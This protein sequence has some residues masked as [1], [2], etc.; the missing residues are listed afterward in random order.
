LNHTEEELIGMLNDFLALPNETEWLEFKEAKNQYDF[1]KIGKYFSALS[2]EACL[3]GE[4]SSWLIFGVNKKHEI[5][6]SEYRKNRPSLD[7]LKHELSENTTNHISF[8]E[9]YELILPEGRI[10]MF[11]IPP[12]I[13]GSPTAW[14]GHYY[15][16]EG[17]SLVALNLQKIDTIRSLSIPDWSAQIIPAA[18]V[19]DLDPNA[20]VKARLEYKTKE[21]S[22]A[23]EI[24]Q[25]DDLTFLNKA[26]VTIQGKITN[27]A[28]LLLGKDESEHF[29]SPSLAKMSWIL[30]DDS[31]IEQDYAHF[32]PPFLLNVNELFSNVRNL[33]YRHMPDGTLFPIEIAQYDPWVIRE[34][35]H[36]C[37]AHQ[38]YSKRGRISVVET[39]DNLRFTN[40]GGFIPGT[41]EKV[42][43]MDSPPEIYRNPFLA[44]AMVNLNMIDTIGGGIKKCSFLKKN[45]FSPCLI[46]I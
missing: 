36:N 27:T 17:E 31:G 9:I 34:A 19:N 20:I 39:P 41:V 23:E 40:V 8:V 15:G 21:P 28:I 11:Q 5:V 44:N 43:E 35:L 38:D 22:R 10:I 26:K 32:A 33:K 13:P 4:D 14:K 6:G 7:R 2:N 42:I 1:N 12:A 3:K 46:M 16:R 18:D 37:I 25:W 30:R 24:D 29:L 45:G